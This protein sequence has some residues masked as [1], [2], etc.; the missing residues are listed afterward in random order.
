MTGILE[1][2]DDE[3]DFDCSSQDSSDS[4]NDLSDFDLA[5]D[6]ENSPTTGI[7]YGCRTKASKSTSKQKG[8][9]KHNTNSVN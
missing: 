5:D 9:C 1:E 8:Y 6:D 3:M 2:I 4:E 7:H